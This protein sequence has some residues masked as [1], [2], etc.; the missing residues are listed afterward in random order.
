MRSSL[1]KTKP[2]QSATQGLYAIS[3]AHQ[4]CGRK[5]G[6][7]TLALLGLLS[8]GSLTSFDAHALAL[9]RLNVLSAIG[10]PLRAEVDI[11]DM[12]AS[13]AESFRPSL[14]SAD[15]YKAMGLDYNPDLS[16]MQFTLQRSPDGSAL[17]LL[18]NSKPATAAFI[19]IV[20]EVS[21]A[22]GKITRD[23]TLL[24]TP[25]KVSVTPTLPITTVA[26]EAEAPAAVVPASPQAP[27]SPSAASP[28]KAASSATPLVRSKPA[29]AKQ[30]T[31][32]RGNTASQL[33]LQGLPV[34]VSLDQMLLAMLRS[35]PDAFVAGNVNR[36]KAGAVLAMPTAADATT[37]TRDDAR[38]SIIAQSRD[39]SAFRQ[40][41]ASNARPAQVTPSG[42]EASGKVQ[43]KVEEKT[44]AATA[45]G[46][47]TLS[48]GA[49]NSVT[50]GAANTEEKLSQVRQAKDA[51]DRLAE[52]SKNISELN[53]L[54]VAPVAPVASDAATTNS[55]DP[56]LAIGTPPAVAA[57][58]RAHQEQTG[59]IDRLS[60]DPIVLA[61][62]AGF[63]GLLLA[64][65]FFRS[66]GNSADKNGGFRSARKRVDSA[67]KDP[68]ES[69][70]PSIDSGSPETSKPA[71]PAVREEPLEDDPLTLAQGELALG[72]EAEA[73]TLL[74]SALKRTP[75]RLALHLE[76][77]DIYIDRDDVAS[78][79]RLAIEA[80]PITGGKGANWERICKKGQ[81]LDP[82]NPLYQ[83]AE[84]SPA[85]T[86]P[87]DKL[88]FDLELGTPA[89]T[90]P[91]TKS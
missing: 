22:S 76:L 54:G 44:A 41:L 36:L 87:F 17:L 72:H 16:S 74:R 34:T 26:V 7:T 60:K 25:P 4:A 71:A 29:A 38:Q 39:F 13:V 65:G 59:L 1:K 11:L 80:L 42:R 89:K 83:F 85:A 47:L 84:S 49:L 55:A 57:A 79:E 91:R 56:G 77:M 53:K 6:A 68:A 75:Q 24:L 63:L 45:A 31:V 46:K 61:A 14:A 19:D 50:S 86:P 8:L 30:V 15:A 70:E 23:F 37:V 40:Q 43:S 20:L 88:D 5:R 69:I 62:A 52:L 32:V 9:G 58:A 90:P 82:T 73:E 48:K 18:S 67:V 27:G 21:W 12:T 81:A 10:E 66:R 2:A 35:N 64:W 78:F 28:A 3:S 51:A 33:A